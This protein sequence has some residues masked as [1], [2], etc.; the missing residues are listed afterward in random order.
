MDYINQMPVSKVKTTATAGLTPDKIVSKLFSFHNI[1]HFFHLQTTSFAQ[2]KMLDEV[3][4]GIGG[5]KD[6]ISEYL[7]GCQAP[8]RFS[9]LTLDSVPAYSEGA[10]VSFLKQ[11]YDFSCQLCEYAESHDYEQLCNLSSELQGI[12]V[13]GQYLNTL[14]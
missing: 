12:F 8:K 14:K 7:L 13:K 4:G 3:Y 2:H 11:G 1:A 5:L 6:S 10:V 9:S